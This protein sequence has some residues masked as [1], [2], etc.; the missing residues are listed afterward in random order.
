MRSFDDE[1]L[2]Q[3]T[4]MQLGGAARR[5][6]EVEREDEALRLLRS[7][8]EPFYLLGGGSNVVVSDRGLEQP[9]VVLA[10]RGVQRRRCG[11][12]VELDAAAGEPW[13]FLVAQTVADGL[14]GIE[15]LSGIP[16]WVGATPIQNIGAYGQQV[17]DCI[18]RVRAY[19]LRDDR[20]VQL[21]AAQCAFGYRTS[22]FKGSGRGRYVVLGVTYRLRSAPPA[23]PR[24]ADLRRALRDTQPTLPQIRQA[25]LDLRRSRSMVLDPN[26]PDSRSA[27]SFF[28]NPV[29]DRSLADRIDR[30]TSGTPMP[31]FV[32]EAGG[33][34]VKLA[35]AWL[36]EQA[37]FAKGHG[38]G[39]VGLSR[40]HALAIVNRGGGTAREVI[41]LAGEI[42][43][44]V[45]GRFG[46]RLR[47]E[48]ALL[49]FDRDEIDFASPLPPLGG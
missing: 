37:G 17:A 31:R 7:L 15:C 24:Y 32:E 48:P 43:R 10:L 27:G 8:K 41:D 9:V 1:S 26:D 11:E 25:V 22:F 5:L 46:V 18:D 19:D 4:T 36:I 23:P 2:A 49:G 21:P 33:A 44:S 12:L 30:L 42:H 3:R 20:V 38:D 28:L 14:A 29:V 34:R 35:A 16:G 39:P 40:Q 6:I 47:V 45:F 13:D